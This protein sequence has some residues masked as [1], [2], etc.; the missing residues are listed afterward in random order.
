MSW[1][2]EQICGLWDVVADFFTGIAEWCYEAWITFL[3]ASYELLCELLF[4][5]IQW[6]ISLGFDIDPSKATDTAKTIFEYC[7]Q[8]NWI[9]PIGTMAQIFFAGLA[10]RLGIRLVRFIIG[11]IPTIEG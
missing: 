11:W 9:I 7:K 8:I 3:E 5:M 1:L 6:L 4:T 10:V 2:W